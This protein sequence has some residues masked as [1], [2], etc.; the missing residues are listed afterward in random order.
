MK[1]L[2]AC[3]FSGTVRDAFARFGHDAWSCDI[4]PSDRGGQHLQDDA[5]RV[6]YNGR[7]DLMNSHNGFQI[8]HS[9]AKM[10]LNSLWR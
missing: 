1:I 10:L 3:E 8:A 5:L 2:V 9:T 7:W 6:A 4:L